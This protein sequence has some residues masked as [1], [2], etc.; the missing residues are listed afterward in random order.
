MA[1]LTHECSYATPGTLGRRVVKSV[2]R[3]VESS[4]RESSPR[5]TL[6]LPIRLEQTDGTYSIA[7]GNRYTAYSSSM[8]PGRIAAPENYFIRT[9]KTNPSTKS[10]NKKRPS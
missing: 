6:A 5:L 3:N 9:C 8:L 4:L 2:H 1:K 10:E 7:T